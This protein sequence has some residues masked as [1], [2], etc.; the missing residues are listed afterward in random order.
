MEAKGK[1]NKQG[2]VTREAK[3]TQAMMDK[4][5]ADAHVEL[6]GCSSDAATGTDW[7]PIEMGCC[8]AMIAF[9]F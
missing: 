7:L 6:R 4:W 3:V 2:V 9:G 1:R 8:I 5:V